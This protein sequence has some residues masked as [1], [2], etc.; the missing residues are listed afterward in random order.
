[1]KSHLFVMVVIELL[2]FGL[3]TLILGLGIGLL[4]DQLIYAL[5]ENHGDKVVAVSTFQPA[6]VIAVAVFYAFVF[7]AWWLAIVCAW[8]LDALQLVKKNS[9]EKKSRFLFLQTLLGLAALAYGYFLA[10]G[11]TNP[12]S[13]VFTFF[14]AVL[15]VILG[16][17]LLF[18]AGITVFL[19]FLK[20]GSPIIMAN[21]MISFN[22]IFRMKKMRV[23]AT[24]IATLSTM[25]L[26]TL[27]GGANIYAGGDYLQRLCFLMI[28]AFRKRNHRWADG[29]VLTEFV[30]EQGY[31]SQREG[32]YPYYTMGVTSRAGSSSSI[33]M[34]PLK[35]LS[36]RKRIFWLFQKLVIRVWRKTLDL[37]DD[38]VALYQQG[39]KL[40]S[41]KTCMAGQTFKIKEELKGAIFVVIYLIRW[42]NMI[43]PE[44]LHGS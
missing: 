9:G 22:L 24:T 4:F 14:V 20:R 17:Y 5:A 42:R 13:A 7:S 10:L 34:L 30:N 41:S 31:Q 43:V 26:V 18:N 11:V 28:L 25:V 1:M 23:D 38:E 15:F 27:S 2:V 44:N 40:D 6:V 8:K 33:S 19:Q 16:T 12:L 29:Q 3:V 32:V 35:N 37:G 39:V 21:N 36:H